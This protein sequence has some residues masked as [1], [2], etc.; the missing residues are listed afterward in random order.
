M[1]FLTL[2]ESCLCQRES[3]LIERYGADRIESRRGTAAEER[4][5][6]AQS[7]FSMGAPTRLPH[8][9]HEPS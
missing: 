2:C 6:V 1:I 7:P 9:V 4:E 5:I 8:S 3:G